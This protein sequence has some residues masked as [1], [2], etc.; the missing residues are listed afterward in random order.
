MVFYF[1]FLIGFL[2]PFV[3]GLLFPFSNWTFFPILKIIYLPFS[4]WNFFKF[5]NK[6]LFTFSNWNFIS[7]SFLLFSILFYLSP[8]RSQSTIGF[9]PIFLCFIKNIKNC[10]NNNH[11][12]SKKPKMHNLGFVKTRFVN[13][14]HEQII[15]FWIYIYDFIYSIT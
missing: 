12:S 8:F 14:S 7:F 5:L 4:N 6:L 3:I 15:G 1:H 2:F 13:P 9:L 10:Q 11:F